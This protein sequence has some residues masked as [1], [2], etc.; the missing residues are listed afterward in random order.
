[1]AVFALPGLREQFK[2]GA[3]VAGELVAVGGQGDHPVQAGTQQPVPLASSELDLDAQ[4]NGCLIRRSAAL[5][6]AALRRSV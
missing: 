4:S 2:H 6:R 3:D 1:M 5:T